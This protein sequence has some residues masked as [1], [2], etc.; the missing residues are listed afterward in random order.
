MKNKKVNVQIVGNGLDQMANA[1][2]EYNIFAENIIGSC[3]PLAMA[4]KTDSSFFKF[5]DNPNASMVELLNIRKNLSQM[6]SHDPENFCQN[7]NKQPS[8]V[9]VRRYNN[10]KYFIFMNSAIAH[11]LYEKN[12][13]VF[14]RNW[15][16][17]DFVKYIISDKSYTVRTLPFSDDFNWKYYYDQFID[18]VLNEF[19][20]DHIILIKSNSAQW[21]MDEQ[22]ICSFND[23]SCKYRNA[24]EEIDNYFI[25]R[26]ECKVITEHYNHIPHASAKN[27]FP[28]IIRSEKTNRDI[29]AE[30]ANIIKNDTA[31]YN[32]IP[33][34]HVTNGL[35]SALGQRLC[36]SI[37]RDN[38]EN[39]RIIL[40]NDL[41][42]KD[43]ESEEYSSKNEFFYNLSL[44]KDFLS[45]SAPKNLSEYIIELLE[46]KQALTNILD[47]DLINL[48]TKYFKL[49]I[50]D[51]IALYMIYINCDKK[52]D[53]KAAALN[54][55][56]NPECLPVIKTNKVCS[57][58]ISFLNKYPYIDNEFKGKDKSNKVYV[59]VENNCFIVFDFES[60]NIVSQIN[61]PYK[62]DFDYM[63]IV[64][65]GYLCPI[66]SADALTYSYEYYAE[67]ARNGDGKKPSY[68]KFDNENEFYES[69]KYFEYKPL[70]ENDNFVFIIG[71]K[72]PPKPSDYIPLVD[73]TEL[74][75]PNT[76]LINVRN[77]LGDQLC[78]FIMGQAISKFTDRKVIYFDLP[79][80]RW[81]GSFTSDFA[82]LT[83]IPITAFSDIIS[84][85][86]KRQYNNKDYAALPLLMR[87]NSYN[88]ITNKHYFNHRTIQNELKTTSI[89][90]SYIYNDIMSYLNSSM[91][92]S[93]YYNILRMEELK[94][95]FDYKLSDYIEFPPFEEESDIDLCE[96]MSACDAVVIHIRRGDRASLG[97]SEDTA[98]FVEA[99]EKTMTL[100]QYENKKF[101]VFSDD[102][103][104]CEEHQSEIGLD[105]AG[106]CEIVFVEGKSDEDSFRDVQLMTLGKI[107]ICGNS[108]FPRIA[109]MYSEKW[110]MVFCSEKQQFDFFQKYV[111]K[112]KYETTP[113]LKDNYSRPKPN[114]NNSSTTQWEFAEREHEEW[115]NFF[116][117]GSNTKR[118]DRILLIGDSISRMYRVQLIQL[119][120]RPVDLFACSA[121]LSD[122]MFW[123]YLDLFFSFD[124]YRQEKAQIQLGVHGVNGF[125]RSNRQFNSEIWE[126]CYEKLINKVLRHIPDLTIALTTMVMKRDNIEEVDESI[127]NIVIEKN[128]IAR[129]IAEKYNLKLNDLYTL[130]LNQPHTDSVHFPKEGSALI[131]NQVAKV[132]NLL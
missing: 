114:N 44:L 1:L 108:G 103:G 54:I 46:S 34:L 70:L 42:L 35:M 59:P 81:V 14:S 88:L 75:D 6:L 125:G 118:S 76:A 130:M 60:E 13:V 9:G 126:K 20:R 11:P 72:E 7:Y 122:E 86:L 85:R 39:L 101:F 92:Y 33:K 12:G 95:V 51:I 56:N 40:E 23:R 96:K 29:A 36:S 30:I 25:E 105:R 112:N 131:A 45:H 37:L 90:G 26:T 91:P 106:D 4:G 87:I 69:L 2:K 65:N 124:E 109:V 73:F 104:W 63:T 107:I 120:H 49:D 84:T 83:K 64:K 47:V 17:N 77:G 62:K 127:N 97:L 71:D 129:K 121:D 52:D 10:A 61:F 117:W 24:V 28:Y 27:A 41:T 21:Y 15:P 111:R 110:E 67:K 57:E 31:E 123:K 58:N 74:V 5:C 113:F 99:I 82:D 22:N 79:Y 50:N 48:Y 80:L 98:F 53:L 128:N 119:V 89:N 3:N 115:L 38:E 16:E 8:G 43:V 94:S 66:L 93:Y 132:M 32:T 102:I 55:V 68:L 100:S 116:F 18:A 78:H 19:D